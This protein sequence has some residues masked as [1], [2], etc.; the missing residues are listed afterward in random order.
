MPLDMKNLNWIEDHRVLFTLKIL[1]Y[2]WKKYS[3]MKYLLTFF[4]MWTLY[5]KF[6]PYFFY[7]YVYFWNESNIKQHNPKIFH[8][9]LYRNFYKLLCLA[10]VHQLNFHIP[11]FLSVSLGHLARNIE[12]WFV[13]KRQAS[14]WFPDF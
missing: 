12:K 1:A 9:M 4:V 3:F 10:S 7:S 14:F 8:D 13:L 6:M 5:I 11:T 2:L